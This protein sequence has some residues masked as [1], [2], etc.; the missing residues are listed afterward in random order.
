MMRIYNKEDWYKLFNL[1]LFNRTLMFT[2]KQFLKLS[3]KERY[4]KYWCIRN[5]KKSGAPFYQLDLDGV[6]KYMNNKEDKDSQIAEKAPDDYI[7]VQGNYRGDFAEVTFEKEAMGILLRA[8]DFYKKP[9]KKLSRL[10]FQSIIGYE[11]ISYMN[12]LLEVYQKRKNN[13]SLIDDNPIIEFSYYDRPVGI[14]NK[15]LIIWEVRH[16]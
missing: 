7:I 3:P 11:N 6:V 14:L 5:V 15:R 12:E 2:K 16:Y 4:Y 8:K 9:W 10:Q 13:Y 1:N